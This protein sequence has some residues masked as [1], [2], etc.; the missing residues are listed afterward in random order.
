MGPSV[1]AKVIAR[2]V[3]FKWE[4][5]MAHH[6]SDGLFIQHALVLCVVD[7]VSVE[8]DFSSTWGGN[9]LKFLCVRDGELLIGLPDLEDEFLLFSLSEPD[10]VRIVREFLFGD[11]PLCVDLLKLRARDLGWVEFS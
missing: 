4:W 2:E 7:L 1:L 5:E 10:L 3:G 11:D 8:G 6:F 9:W